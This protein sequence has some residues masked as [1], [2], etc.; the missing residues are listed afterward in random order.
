MD[1]LSH[2]LWGGAIARAANRTKPRLSYWWSFWWGVFPDLA[3]FGIPFLWLFSTIAFGPMTFRDLATEHQARAVMFESTYWFG[4]FA[5]T[6]Y[7]Y[8]HSLVIFVG[9]FALVYV[10]RR[11]PTW[12][13]LPWFMH[14][15][16][17]I[18]THTTEF[19]A[20]PFLWPLSD[21]Q[22][23]G[24]MW[25]TPGFMAINYGLLLIV[26]MLLWPRRRPKPIPFQQQPH[27]P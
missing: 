1:V 6:V 13:L 20:T 24:I 14:I 21:F 22:V 3:A 5:P 11:R 25:S 12:E 16:M 19:Y 27:Q 2:G 26:Y 7:L 4:S 18:P 15:L 9:I 23:N 17:D 8:T 10:V